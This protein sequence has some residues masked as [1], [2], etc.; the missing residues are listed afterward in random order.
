MHGG[1]FP[2]HTGLTHEISFDIQRAVTEGIFS[3]MSDESNH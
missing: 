2:I 1:L 3:Q